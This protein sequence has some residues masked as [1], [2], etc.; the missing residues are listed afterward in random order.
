[1]RL[2]LDF[3]HCEWKLA[4]RAKG[5]APAAFSWIDC[6]GSR[7]YGI[8]TNRICNKCGKFIVNHHMVRSDRV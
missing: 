4:E 3:E 2:E 6:K 8:P 5:L 7:H 1:M